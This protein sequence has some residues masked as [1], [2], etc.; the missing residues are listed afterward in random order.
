MRTGDCFVVPKSIPEIIKAHCPG[1][2]EV[3]NAYVR[4]RH[5]GNWSDD[6]SAASSSDTATIL[7][8]C[9]CERLF[10]R[11]DYWFSEWETI[12]EN[13]HTGEPQRE[14]GVET[15]YWP[16]P[17]KRK[18]P[19]WIDEIAAADKTLGRLLSEMYTALNNDL[20]VL[21]AI[22]ARTA[23]DRS[24]E[25]LKVDAALTFSEKLDK[26]VAI[27]KVSETERDTLDVLVD[28]GSAAA[29]R[30]WVP[31]PMELN[32]MMTIVEAFLHRTFILSDGIKKLKAAVPPK[33]PRQKKAKGLPSKK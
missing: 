20:R 28:A 3:R 14:G 6:D 15:T 10:F 11:R 1:C 31:K 22:G 13:P 25:L 21:A 26:L 16:A 17:V 27:G 7:E 32:T 19:D 29:H 8:C 23:F 4:G 33:P 12:V 18:T 9:G 2:G 24:S 30:A 5:V